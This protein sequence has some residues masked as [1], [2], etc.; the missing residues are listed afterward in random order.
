[1]L[2]LP[3]LGSGTLQQVTCELVEPPLSEGFRSSRSKHLL[4]MLWEYLTPLPKSCFQP[5]LYTT[6][7][8]SKICSQTSLFYMKR[9]ALHVKSSL[10]LLIAYHQHTEGQR[11]L[12]SK[13]KPLSKL[14]FC[15]SNYGNFS[16][17][18]I[19]SRLHPQYLQHS[20]A[21]LNLKNNYTKNEKKH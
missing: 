7:K 4:A 15:F 17:F 2:E 18:Y 9:M 3:S 21:I 11:S 1:M 19:I 8:D 5:S 20:M 12:H 14:A 6:L 13:I 10:C 16:V